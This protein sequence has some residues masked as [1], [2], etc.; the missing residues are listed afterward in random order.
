[1]RQ[2][3]TTLIATSALLAGVFGDPPQ[4]PLGQDEDAPY[5]CS[6][7]PYKIHIFSK[8]PLVIYIQDFLTKPEREHLQLLAYVLIPPPKLASPR[9]PQKPPIS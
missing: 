7:P 5:V 2:P 3:L 1:M 4:E 6:H 9:T 8:S